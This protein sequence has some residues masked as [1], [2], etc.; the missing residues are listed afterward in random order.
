MHEGD[1]AGIS[2]GGRCWFYRYNSEL[3]SKNWHAQEL[4]GGKDQK[5]ERRQLFTTCHNNS[6]EEGRRKDLHTYQPNHFVL[7]CEK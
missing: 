2:P 7:K 4:P 1:A 5:V 6:F 3:T